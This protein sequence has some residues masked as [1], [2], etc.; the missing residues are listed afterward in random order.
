MLKKFMSI[1]A[2][3]ATSFG[4][5]LTAPAFVQSAS[6]DVELTISSIE[7]I[8]TKAG[9]IAA[10]IDP[11]YPILVQ[12][13]LAQPAAFGIDIAKPMGLIADMPEDGFAYT[14]FLPV[15]NQSL[16]ETQLGKLQEDGKIPE[17]V[18]VEFKND[19]AVC[20]MNT[21]WTGDV[22]AFDGTKVLSLD[23]KPSALAPLLALAAMNPN[24]Q[25][26]QIEQM[27]KNLA[28]LESFTLDLDV[29]EAGDLDFTFTQVPK[30][31]TDIA[32]NFAN[33]EKLTKS[34]LGSLCDED[35]P[36]TIQ[37]LGTFD[38]NNRRDMVNA[39]TSEETVPEK[40]REAILLAMDV[41]KVDFVLNAD[42]NGLIAAM[43]ISNG[44]EINKMIVD[45]IEELEEDGEV[46]GTANVGKIGKS[47]TIHE[48]QHENG[49]NVAVGVHK[50]YIFLAA[51]KSGK[52]STLLKKTLKAN[53]LKVGTV[54]KNGKVSF[55][56][57]L[58]TSLNPAFEELGLDGKITY[59]VDVNDGKLVGTF[60]AE[61]AIF[62]SLGKLIK[63]IQ[64]S[65]SVET[66]GEENGDEDLFEDD[67]E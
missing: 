7:N 35:A 65:V 23:A 4:M 2:A 37:V 43:G 15:K 44:D 10:K 51:S 46:S 24:V 49:Q 22:P 55:D 59:I 34:L 8:Q 31:G 54:E 38:E 56:M 42:A 53:P 27:Q 33:S 6:H 3:F 39:L 16:F 60:H 62:E 25:Q 20:C 12:M 19:F 40:L 30:E 17:D 61:S 14:I 32:G 36:F 48:L 9:V 45:A 5:L 11:N 1:S 28:Q 58:I 18:K 26:E 66:I 67:E 29:S 63:S 52:A 41:E 13:V 47:I 21:E 64:P 57:D 50:K